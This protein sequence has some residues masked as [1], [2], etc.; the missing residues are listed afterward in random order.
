MRPENRCN[1]VLALQCLIDAVDRVEFLPDRV[2]S[3]GRR[4]RARPGVPIF[5]GRRVDVLLGLD[6][7]ADYAEAGGALLG[8]KCQSRRRRP[9]HNR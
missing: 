9:L 3:A 8:R 2:T 6:N 5:S 7:V 1:R 4:V